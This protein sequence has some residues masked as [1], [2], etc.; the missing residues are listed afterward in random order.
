[1]YNI[2]QGTTAVPGNELGIFGSLGD[3]YTQ[4]DLD[5]FFSKL[6]GYLHPISCAGQ[7]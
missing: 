2:T 1:M 3:V 4:S 7:P 5:L 6:A